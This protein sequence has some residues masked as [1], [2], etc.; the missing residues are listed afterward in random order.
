MTNFSN[1]EKITKLFTAG[2]FPPLKERQTKTFEY[3]CE[4]IFFCKNTNKQDNNSI[5]QLSET[6]W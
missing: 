4:K 6:K 5:I 3:G 2:K 1:T